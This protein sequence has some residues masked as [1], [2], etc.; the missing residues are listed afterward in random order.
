MKAELILPDRHIY[1]ALSPL[2]LL[3]L[4]P[5]TGIPFVP[6]TVLVLLFLL[7]T[8]LLTPDPPP[9]LSLNCSPS[10]VFTVAGRGALPSVHLALKITVFL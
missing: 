9:F 4:F 7:K 8:W 1:P 10:V 3:S 5:P 6:L 2:S